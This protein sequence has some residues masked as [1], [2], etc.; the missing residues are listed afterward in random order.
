MNM[1]ERSFCSGAVSFD[2]AL[3][4]SCVVMAGAD[5][6]VSLGGFAAWGRGAI[7]GRLSVA[8]KGMSND[9]AAFDFPYMPVDP[10]I[11][12]DPGRIWSEIVGVD[13]RHQ[14]GEFD[15]QGGGGVD[16]GDYGTWTYVVY[17]ELPMEAV[18]IDRIEIVVS[19]NKLDAE[20]RLVLPGAAL[21]QALESAV[22][23]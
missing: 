3:D 14:R 9:D 21:R 2:I 7:I 10:S 15:V 6:A 4:Q 18:T 13:G 5:C 22:Q 1:P 19:W 20:S 12:S 16:S 17:Q 8:T 23:L 11:G